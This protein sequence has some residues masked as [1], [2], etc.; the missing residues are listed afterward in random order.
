[1]MRLEATDPETRITEIETTAEPWGRLIGET[2]EGERCSQSEL[3]TSN[4]NESFRL[5]SCPKKSKIS[6]V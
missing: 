2:D 3:R 5:R 4:R 1:L 6:A